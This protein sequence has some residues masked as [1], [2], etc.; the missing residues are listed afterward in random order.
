MITAALTAACSLPVAAAAWY[1]APMTPRWASVRRL[2]QWCRTTQSLVLTYDD[3]PGQ[4]ATPRLLDL[5][6]ERGVQ[7]TF[8]LVG[9]R[10]AALPDL[11]K[12]IVTEGHEIGCHTQRHLN[13]WG[14]SPHQSVLDV[15]E[16]YRSL[17]PWI[18]T[19]ARYRPPYGKLNAA[20]WLT[21]R[22]R[23]APISWWTEVAGDVADDA[24]APERVVERVRRAGGGVVLLHDFHRDPHRADLMLKSTALLLDAARAEGW[25]VRSLG[26]LEE[27]ARVS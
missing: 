25:S 6:N 5:L 13:A 23:R 17:S 26:E 9:E 4:C 27:V 19:D 3:G 21:V 20:T 1:L 14:R 8:F 2:R 10:A 24:P 15:L 22:R 12:R 16:G 11:V 18:A 7:A